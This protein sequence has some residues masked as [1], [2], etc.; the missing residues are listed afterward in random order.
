MSLAV[1]FYSA[2]C[3][4]SRR[5]GRPKLHVF[6]REN[7]PA[8]LLP[9]PNSLLSGSNDRTQRGRVPCGRS[10][11]GTRHAS[12]PPITLHVCT[13]RHGLT[14]YPPP[15]DS[16]TLPLP[17]PALGFAPPRLAAPRR[18][19]RSHGV[20]APAQGGQPLQSHRRKHSTSP[21][22]FASTLLESRRSGPPAN[23]PASRSGSARFGMLAIRAAPGVSRRMG[24]SGFPVCSMKLWFVVTG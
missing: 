24:F 23:L 2:P 9:E 21:L 8:I 6:F 13:T 14:A 7:L 18:R 20:L 16:K 22:H 11:H 3:H 19:C 12:T 15:C 17:C 10:G 1:F 4:I 5:F